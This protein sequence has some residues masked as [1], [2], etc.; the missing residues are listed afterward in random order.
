M[1]LSLLEKCLFHTVTFQVAVQATAVKSRCW[2]LISHYPLR[3]KSIVNYLLKKMPCSYPVR[4][5]VDGTGAD[6]NSARLRGS[7]LRR[8]KAVLPPLLLIGPISVPLG[9]WHS[10]L[11]CVGTSFLSTSQFPFLR[12]TRRDTNIHG[13]FL[14]ICPSLAKNPVFNKRLHLW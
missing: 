1:T 8:V 10:I 4:E 3:F 12:H 5:E 11:R 9:S 14:S 2:P 13:Q 7:V 6:R